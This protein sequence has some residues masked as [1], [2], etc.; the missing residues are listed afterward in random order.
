MDPISPF[1]S[2]Q[3]VLILDGGL[4]TELEARGFDLAGDLWS[5]RLLPQRPEAIRD[6]HVDYLTAGADC[7]TSASYQAT[8]EGFVQRGLDEAAAEDLLRLAA[9]LAVEARDAFWR[10]PDRRRGRL[11]PLVAASVGPYGAY[12]ADGSEYTGAYDLD[13]DALMGFHRRRLEIL[14]A[15]GADL[16]A[17]ETVP[18]HAEARAL[19]RLLDEVPGPPAWLSFCCRDARSLSDGSDLASVARELE[20]HER[21]VAFGVNCTAPRYVPSLIGRLRES[22]D[23]PIAVYPNSGEVWDA[24][25]KRWGEPA[26]AVDFGAASVA[27]RRAGARLIGGCCR[28][29]PADVSEIRACLLG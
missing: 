8:I 4:A 7:V 5:A 17:C 29:G 11:R 27:W 15:S 28:T 22:T 26:A 2:R 3:G 9:D 16:L 21:I 10:D 24:T 12:L 1:L 13:E 6:L 23:T 25:A 20:G 18:C 14:S 19:V